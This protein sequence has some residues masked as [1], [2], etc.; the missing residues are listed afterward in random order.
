[1][2]RYQYNTIHCDNTLPGIVVGSVFVWLAGTTGCIS[3][4]CLRSVFPLCRL[5]RA[6]LLATRAVPESAQ[7]AD[8]KRHV[9]WAGIPNLMSLHGGGP[10]R[11]GT[12][13][14]GGIISSIFGE[15]AL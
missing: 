9:L 7:F 4:P 2:R 15:G 11:L 14:A 5:R 1:M 12:D 13:L 6:A 8:S 3:I 10:A